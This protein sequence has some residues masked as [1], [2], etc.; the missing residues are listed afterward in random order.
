MKGGR[1]GMRGKRVRDE[2]GEMRERGMRREMGEREGEKK[3]E[4]EK[5]H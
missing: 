2:G 5:A 3:W 1:G 4:K